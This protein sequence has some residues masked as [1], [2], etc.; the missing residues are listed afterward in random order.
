MGLVTAGEIRLGT[1]TVGS[2][3]TGIRIFKDGST[4]RIEGYENGVLQFYIDSNGKAYFG[5]GAC[6]LDAGGYHQE[7]GKGNIACYKA[8][9]YTGDGGT[10]GRQITVGFLCKIVQVSDPTT[11][12]ERTWFVSQRTGYGYRFNSDTGHVTWVNLAGLHASDGFSVA[13]GGTSFLNVN[14]TVYDYITQG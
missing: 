1:G 13:L 5:G 12:P 10:A 6:W 9:Q 7:P 4:Y 11:S 2:N 8:S 14:G 3:F